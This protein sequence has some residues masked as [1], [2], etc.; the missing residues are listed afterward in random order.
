MGL[1]IVSQKIKIIGNYS[2]LLC[3]GK[4]AYLYRKRSKVR[5]GWGT[6][7]DDRKHSVKSQLYK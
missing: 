6:R 2:I 1:I 4:N 3:L 7:E 5:R